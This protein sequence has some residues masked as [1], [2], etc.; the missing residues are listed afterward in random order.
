MYSVF[1]SLIQRSVKQNAPCV[2]VSDSMLSKAKCTV[3]LRHF[4]IQGGT[5]SLTPR[6]RKSTA[7]CGSKTGGKACLRVRRRQRC[8]YRI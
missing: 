7:R 3:C 6:Y 8:V 2:R 1:V 5:A 4:L